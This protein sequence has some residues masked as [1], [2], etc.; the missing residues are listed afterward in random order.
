[1]NIVPFNDIYYKNCFYNPLFSSIIWYNK[2]FD[3]LIMN[4]SFF[5]LID[6]NSFLGITVSSKSAF[7]ENK[8]LNRIGIKLSKNEVEEDEFINFIKDKAD[9]DVPLMIE[10]DSFLYPRINYYI[11]G[12]KSTHYVMITGYDD[13]KKLL[14]IIESINETKEE[15]VDY[16]LLKKCHFSLSN[17]NIFII[18]NIEQDNTVSEENIRKMFIDNYSEMRHDFSDNLDLLDIA[19]NKILSFDGGILEEIEDN[20]EKLFYE[21]QNIIH[22]KQIDKYKAHYLFDDS[23]DLNYDRIIEKWNMIKNLIIKYTL[24]NDKAL[25]KR[26]VIILDEIKASENELFELL[27]ASF[28]K[29]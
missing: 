8:I 27:D 13:D 29:E 9:H 26:A 25:L 2:N 17:A 18:L 28:D 7:E 6:E 23:F 16:E 11:N 20:P 19:K 22:I 5:Y 21:F 15:K 12:D 14:H 4:E 10:I 1:M 24:L 3:P